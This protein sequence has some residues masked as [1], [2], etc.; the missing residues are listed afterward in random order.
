MLDVIVVGGGPAG[1]VAAAVLAGAGCRVLVA[2]RARFP[3]SKPCGDYLNPGCAGVLNRIGALGDVEH[4]ALPVP[5]WRIV[6]PDG[7]AATTAFSAGTGF[8]LPR[9]TLDHILLTR[10]VRMGAAVI[11]AAQVT[12][13]GRGPGGVRVT[14][15]RGAGP[16]ERE[17]LGARLVIGADGLRS[18][19]ARMIGAGAAPRGGR[20]TVGA[21]LEGLDGTGASGERPPGEIHFARDRFC[22][23]A[24]LPGGLANVTIALPAGALRTWRGDLEAGY[25]TAL[26]AFPGLAGRLAGARTVG[27]LRAS[28]PVGYRRRRAVGDGVL[29][30]GDAA[31]LINP[32]TG[33]GMFL[34]L[35]GG[36]L[37]GL[38]ALRALD[39]GGPTR[40]A[41]AAYDRE[42]RREFGDAFLVSRILDNLAFRPSVVGRAVRAMAGR[43]ALGTRF[44]DGVGG[45]SRAASVMHPRLLAG[46]LG[47]A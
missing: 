37:A 10:A 2:E 33:Q 5:G 12:A 40:R 26:R 17:V 38:A 28:G 34:A 30:A 8:A 31:A 36:E 4:A 19:I 24:H 22:G 11:E 42:R 18:A 29:L 46:L 13:L 25:W 3:R 39:R 15:E 16:G 6:A 47:I 9:R 41:L 21:Y 20:F 35:R 27:R 1:S 45:V 32:M 14:I 7:A 43:S 44:I 23:I